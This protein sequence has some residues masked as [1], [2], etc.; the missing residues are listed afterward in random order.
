LVRR[1]QERVGAV[2]GIALADAD[3]RRTN[4]E[5]IRSDEFF[6]QRDGLR[7]DAEEI[8]EGVLLQAANAYQE[9]KRATPSVV[10]WEFIAQRNM[11]KAQVWRPEDKVRHAQAMSHLKASGYSIAPKAP[12]R[13]G[14]PSLR[15][16][17]PRWAGRRDGEGRVITN[18]TP[19]A[20]V[21]P[22]QA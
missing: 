21:R 10:D 3:T 8:L 2:L 5:A 22:V 14:A 7:S 17:D 18:R 1:Q 9:H 19:T 4:G 15:A 11:Q 6:E 12:R 20:I 13:G 16:R